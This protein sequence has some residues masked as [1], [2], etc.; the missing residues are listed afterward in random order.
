MKYHILNEFYIIGY[1][2]AKKASSE[3]IYTT[4]SVWK[5]PYGE[6]FSAEK[7]GSFWKAIVVSRKNCV[8]SGLCDR[9]LHRRLAI[10]NISSLIACHF[11]TKLVISP[12]ASHD[13][14]WWQL[15]E[16]KPRFQVSSCLKINDKLGLSC[17]KLRANFD[18]PG[19][20]LCLCL[21]CFLGLW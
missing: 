19:Y 16:M 6:K 7:V 2:N 12:K 10:S 4:L 5:W 11:H 17:T 8:F 1:K 15:L 14:L 21:I 13:S 9:T 20:L 18:L 3:I